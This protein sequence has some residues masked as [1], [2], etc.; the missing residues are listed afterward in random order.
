MQ[1]K[2][3]VIPSVNVDGVAFI[4]DEFLKTGR[5]PEKRKNM[6]VQSK[7]CTTAE[8]GVDLNRNYDFNWGVGDT[9]NDKECDG[10]TY[11]GAAP[12]SEPETRAIRDFVTAKK[13][14]LRFVYNLHCSGN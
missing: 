5:L 12:F 1:N 11:G 3:Y 9:A 4:E 8:A 10:E 14:E 13:D 7:E 2:Y 6:N